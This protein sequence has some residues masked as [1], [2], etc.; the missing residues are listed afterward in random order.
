LVSR[1]PAS[2]LCTG[3][4]VTRLRGGEL[5]RGFVSGPFGT[6]G[7]VLRKT[8]MNGNKSNVGFHR[9]W[10][11]HRGDKNPTGLGDQNLQRAR[12][13]CIARSF[14][15]LCK[16]CFVSSKLVLISFEP[17]SRVNR[18]EESCF[19][20]CSVQSICIPN[21]VEILCKSCFAG[22]QCKLLKINS[23]TFEWESKLKPIEESCFKFCSLQSICIP[24]S[25]V[26]IDASAFVGCLV[27]TISV[28]ADN[29]RFKIERDF[30]I[31]FI[32][33]KLIRYFGL[34]VKVS[35]LSE[36]ETLGKFCFYQSTIESV[37]FESG[38]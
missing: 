36:I 38:S 15:A 21:S 4:D 8:R 9:S 11:V 23:I 34:N 6:T 5:G 28:D 35:I 33:R 17:G 31:D 3:W 25:V 29:I 20:F 7:R 24:S 27:R 37:G 14:D 10:C 13:V 16:S 18:I 26:W 30:R 12:S 2:I 32:E 1:V 22:S 19:E